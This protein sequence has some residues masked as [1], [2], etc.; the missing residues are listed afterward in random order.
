MARSISSLCSTVIIGLL[1]KVPVAGGLPLTICQSPPVWSATW[2]ENDSI[3]F[4]TSL[5][6]SGLWL[7][8]ANGG[9]PV[10]IT[11]PKSDEAHHGFPQL[12]AH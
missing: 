3:V 2:G 12:R 10:Q 9:E 8:S 4:A 7:V 11:T 1:H 6:S 5:P